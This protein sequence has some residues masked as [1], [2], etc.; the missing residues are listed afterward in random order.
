M[1][2]ELLRWAR[3]S[4]ALGLDFGLV[5]NGLMLS[6]PHVVDELVN[7]CRLRYVY[8]SMHGGTP[9]VHGSVVR[10]DTFAQAMKAVETLHGRVPDFTVNCVVTTANVKHLRGLVDR[11]VPFPELCIKLSMTQPKGGWPCAPRRRPRPDLH[12]AARAAP[13][14][15][16]RFFGVPTPRGHAFGVQF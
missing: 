12:G 11:L 16:T 2:P 3:K 4:A 6:Y 9:K 14:Q 13:P 7:D 1:S 8:M 15:K 10:A 5:T